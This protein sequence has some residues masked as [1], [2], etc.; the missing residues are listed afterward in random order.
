MR[1]RLSALAAVLAALGVLVL[2]FCLP[3]IVSGALDRQLTGE[4]RELAIQE[5]SLSRPGEADIYDLLRLMGGEHTQVALSQGENM[6]AEEAVRRAEE[7]LYVQVLDI[8][9]PSTKNFTGIQAEPFLVT[10]REAPQLSGI[11]WRCTWT[12]PHEQ[13]GTLFLEDG[14]GRLVSFRVYVPPVWQKDMEPITEDV[15]TGIYYYFHEFFQADVPSR[16]ELP[17]FAKEDEC[18]IPLRWQDGEQYEAAL[19]LEGEW[20]SFNEPREGTSISISVGNDMGA[21]E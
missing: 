14:D 13:Q 8:W 15:V 1:R 5:V 19:R 12:D 7:L 21:S 11:F 2:G 10:S 20:L 4:R 18:W 9:R 17:N 6:T 16:Q 3:R